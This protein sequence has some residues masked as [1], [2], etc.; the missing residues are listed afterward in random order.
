MNSF[1]GINL[2]S[3]CLFNSSS[4]GL[5]TFNYL[6]DTNT[7][8]F[9]LST[10]FFVVTSFVPDDNYYFYNFEFGIH[11]N[12]KNA[13]ILGAT[14]YQY[15]NP[16]FVTWTD[17]PKY[18]GYIL[19]YGP[20]IGHYFFIWKGLFFNSIVNPL[21]M[22]YRKL[23]NTRINRGF[24]LLLAFRAGYRINFKIFKQ[25]LFI[26]PGLE[27][28]YKLINTQVP[29]DFLHIDNQYARVMYMPALNVGI[30]F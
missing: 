12:R 29:E 24:L 6:K 20:V 14:I 10:S 17:S 13:I 1:T 28:N 21:V 27:L 15:T 22:D 11:T 3:Q 7:Y 2:K 25:K 16:E 18:N 30:K 5:N 23:D 19:S 9:F 26:E 4:C 8:K